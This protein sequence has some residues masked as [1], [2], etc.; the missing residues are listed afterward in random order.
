MMGLPESGRR[1]CSNPYV[2]MAMATLGM[3]AYGRRST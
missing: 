1:Y 2:L 3:M